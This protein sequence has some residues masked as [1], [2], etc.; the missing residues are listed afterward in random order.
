MTTEELQRI[1]QRIV[2]LNNTSINTIINTITQ[3]T[4]KKGDRCHLFFFLLEE[5]NNFH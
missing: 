4:Q 5:K 2:Q 3:V 1:V